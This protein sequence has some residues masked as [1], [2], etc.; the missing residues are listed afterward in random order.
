MNLA[1]L[2]ALWDLAGVEPPAVD[3]L[4]VH[5]TGLSSIGCDVCV[6]LDSTGRRHLLIAL[7][8]ESA[9]V[10][11]FTGAGLSLCLRKLEHQD[12][13]AT[14][15]DLACMSQPLN[16]VFSHL[17][18]DVLVQ[19]KPDDPDAAE[20]CLRILE[21]WK[22]L[23]GAGAAGMGREK[24]IGLAGELIILDRLTATNPAALSYWDGPRPGIH[25]FRCHRR[26]LE[27]KTSTRRHGRF[28]TISG[29]KQLEAPAAGDLH[30]AVL[31][32]ERN[33]GGSIGLGGLVEK[34]RRNGV[35]PVH[36]AKLLKAA[37][38]TP[39]ESEEAD[40]SRF[41]LMELLIY[42]VGESFPKIV[43]ASFVYGD[44]P[45]GILKISYD[46]DLTG[47]TPA[48]LSQIR[49][50]AYLRTFATGVVT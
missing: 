40:N 49:A 16:D 28:L 1:G 30:V 45:A 17:V 20:K 23:F 6:G 25:D 48:P 9:D 32:L 13:A 37:G 42:E 10:S 26:A 22:E 39:G 47:P 8:G 31:K 2:N 18:L 4:C 19:F 50:E 46:I 35:D 33:P 11:E 24:I 15:L 44:L 43:S 5:A 14:Y 34:I 3:A 7:S 12:A 29:H 21:E 38:Y 41:D 27:V 36:L